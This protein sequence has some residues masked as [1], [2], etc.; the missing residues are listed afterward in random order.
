MIRKLKEGID[1]EVA[2]DNDAKVR[3]IVEETLGNIEKNGDQAV[4]EYAKKFDNWDGDIKLSKEFIAGCYERLSAQ[5][6]SDIKFAQ[7]Q[8]RNFA[9]INVTQCKMLKLRRCLV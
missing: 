9:Q 8:V 3:A 5:V 4:R 6:I 1:S 7:T 2:A